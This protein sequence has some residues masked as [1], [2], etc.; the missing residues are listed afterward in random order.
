MLNAK[1]NVISVAAAIGRYGRDIVL[2]VGE[3]SDNASQIS[4]TGHNFNNIGGNVKVIVKGISP[5]QYRDDLNALEKALTNRHEKIIAELKASHDEEKQTILIRDKQI[6][7]KELVAVREKMANLEAS[8]LQ[9]I[10]HLQQQIDELNDY[11]HMFSDEVLREAQQALANGDDSQAKAI[12]IKNTQL[13]KI[14]DKQAAKAE[15]AL[16]KMAEEKIQYKEAYQHYQQAVKRNEKN[17]EY[18]L[19]A[20]RL[21]DYLAFYDQAI[22]Y[23]EAALKLQL[24][25]KGGALLEVAVL[26]NNLDLVWGNK[27]EYDKAIGYYEKALVS[28]KR[29]LGDAHPNTLLVKENLEFV[30]RRFAQSD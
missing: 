25:A 29:S 15:F 21:A 14:M 1:R 17:T 24:K 30:K 5:K 27:G 9:C 19:Y 23:Y 2:L 13:K 12:Y 18:L 7:E 22:A 26:W 11:Q 3:Q 4:E 8:Y 6:L 16:S 20:D 28:L 10:T